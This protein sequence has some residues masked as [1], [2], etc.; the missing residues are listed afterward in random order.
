[1]AV[2]G[3]RHAALL[4][5]ALV[6]VITSLVL[7]DY[8]R[9]MLSDAKHAASGAMDGFTLTFVLGGFVLASAAL[10]M[11]QASRIANRVEGPER[12]LIQALRRM[13]GGDLSFRVHLR[14]GDPLAGV[15]RECNELLD[16]LNAN[17]PVG[18]RVGGDIVDV[19]HER[20]TEVAP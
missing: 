5:P 10:V 4:L 20:L 2:T 1:M 17:P 6:I 11:V 18:A 15:A 13:R 9:Q 3:I 12:R 8:C 7:T 16:W 19:G 14:R